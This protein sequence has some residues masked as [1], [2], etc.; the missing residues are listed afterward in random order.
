VERDDRFFPLLGYDVNLDLALLNVEDGIRWLS[1]SKDI[2]GFL[3]A[4]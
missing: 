1:L 2:F 4:I 3:G